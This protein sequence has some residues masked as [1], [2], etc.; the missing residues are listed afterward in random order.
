[1]TV[2][3]AFTLLALAAAAASGILHLDVVE[4][5]RGCTRFPPCNVPL[6]RA[7]HA[8]SVSASTCD[9]TVRPAV[10]RATWSR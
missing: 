9:V 8:A 7:I 10:I 6:A 2:D 4:F 5:W 1:M 3:T